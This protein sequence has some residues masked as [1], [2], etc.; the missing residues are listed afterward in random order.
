MFNRFHIGFGS[1]WLTL[2]IINIILG[3]IFLPLFG[4]GIPLIILGVVLTTFGG[5]ELA[6]GIDGS[7]KGRAHYLATSKSALVEEKPENK[8]ELTK[9]TKLGIAPNL[10]ERP[11]KVE[12]A[13][14]PTPAVATTESTEADSA[15]AVRQS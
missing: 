14:D 13:K 10:P 6:A 11:A 7:V 5:L 12:R 8:P 9:P 3:A 15:P 2:G 1:L 4:A